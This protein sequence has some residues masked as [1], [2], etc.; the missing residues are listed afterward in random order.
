MPSASSSSRTP[1]SSSREDKRSNKG[2]QP[3]ASRPRSESVSDYGTNTDHSSDETFWSCKH[4]KAQGKTKS[5][6]KKSDLDKHVKNTHANEPPFV[7]KVMGLDDKCPFKTNERETFINHIRK[8]HPHLDLNKENV[9]VSKD[10]KNAVD[11]EK[12]QA[13]LRAKKEKSEKE[14][15]KKR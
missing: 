2:A 6:S 14:Q 10:L 8:K 7:C 11:K 12:A 13:A 4:C 15:G 1:N 3:K 5:Y 9:H